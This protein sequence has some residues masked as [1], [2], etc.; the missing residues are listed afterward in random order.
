MFNCR[1]GIPNNLV[2]ALVGP[3]T[4]IL[5]LGITGGENGVKPTQLIPERSAESRATTGSPERRV[6]PFVL[7]SVFIF[8]KTGFKFCLR[9]GTVLFIESNS[10][11]RRVFKV[12]QGGSEQIRAGLDVL[13]EKNNYFT[14]SC[15]NTPIH[16]NWKTEV[17]SMAEDFYLGVVLLQKT[18]G[19]IC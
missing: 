11:D 17:L 2:A 8:D 19:V 6:N 15:T 18:A 10:K 13:I 5:I 1:F 12:R 4:Q 9:P 3:E 16:R 14:G 7:K